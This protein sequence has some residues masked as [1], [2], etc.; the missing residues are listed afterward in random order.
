MKDFLHL[1]KR[2]VAAVVTIVAIV[3]ATAYFYPGVVSLQTRTLN[4]KQFSIEGHRKLI[5]RWIYRQAN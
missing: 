5:R 2:T 4:G 3:I 1:N